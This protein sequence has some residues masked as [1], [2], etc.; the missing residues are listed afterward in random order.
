MAESLKHPA[1]DDFRLVKAVADA[2][3]MP[4]AAA[5]LGINQSTVFRRLGQVED[6]LA[7]TLFERHRTG[8]GLMPGGEE[9]FALAQRLDSDI[10]RSR[11]RSPARR[12]PRTASC[13]SPPRG[14]ASSSIFVAAE[15]G[16]H[17]ALIEGLR[18]AR[19]APMQTGL[20]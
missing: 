2:R 8:Y 16:K 6:A 3:G 18:P 14:F 9:M 13:G 10:P 5:E 4:G 15:I 20:A 12:S 19:V 1:W 11:A 7:T 17:R